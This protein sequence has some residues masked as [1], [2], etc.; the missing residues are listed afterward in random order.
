MPIGLDT[1]VPVESAFVGVE[2]LHIC[3]C[4]VYEDYLVLWRI[5]RTRAKGSPAIEQPD[6]VFALDTAQFVAEGCVY[7]VYH[8]VGGVVDP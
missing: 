2:T 7:L 5:T 6:V 4:P 8:V 3:M 1:K